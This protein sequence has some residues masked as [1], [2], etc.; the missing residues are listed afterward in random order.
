MTKEITTPKFSRYR[1]RFRK[2]FCGPVKEYMNYL[3]EFMG[4]RKN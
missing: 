3:R 1:T 4:K 2:V